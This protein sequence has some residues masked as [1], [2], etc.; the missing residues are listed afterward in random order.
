M[1][2]V[3]IWDDGVVKEFRLQVWSNVVLVV[4]CFI[5]WMGMYNAYSI[6]ELQL[7]RYVVRVVVVHFSE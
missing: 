3:N 2:L 5:V 7:V 1:I 4:L 6:F